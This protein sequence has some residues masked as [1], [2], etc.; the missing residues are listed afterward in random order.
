MPVAPPTL[1]PNR[2]T[3]HTWSV[4]CRQPSQ[5]GLN[6]RRVWDPGSENFHKKSRVIGALGD[7]HSKPLALGPAR[8]G[9]A[10][11]GCRTQGCATNAPSPRCG[12]DHCSSEFLLN[13]IAEQSF[14]SLSGGLNAGS[15]IWT[16]PI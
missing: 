14:P 9:K 12:N 10:F 16:H 7:I 4:T 6:V 5:L 11:L 2:R 15:R 8:F 1:A 3:A 13:K